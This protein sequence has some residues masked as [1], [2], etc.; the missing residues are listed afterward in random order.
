MVDGSCGYLLCR[1]IARCRGRSNVNE[2]VAEREGSEGQGDGG[3]G[4]EKGSKRGKVYLKHRSLLTCGSK[5]SG[6]HQN[7]TERSKL[8]VDVQ[9]L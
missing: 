7:Q 6:N 3:N 9:N 5:P 1:G 4:N 8:T 2:G